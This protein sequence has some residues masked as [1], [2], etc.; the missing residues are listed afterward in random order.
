[1]MY[2]VMLGPDVNKRG[3]VRDVMLIFT[4]PTIIRFKSE[5]QIPVLSSI[6]ERL[7]AFRECSIFTDGSVVQESDPVINTFIPSPA[8]ARMIGVKPLVA[9]AMVARPCGPATHG[10]SIAF[11]AV[12]GQAAGCGNSY[13]IEMVMLA[14]ACLVRDQMRMEG[15]PLFAIWSDCKSAVDKASQVDLARVRKSGHKDHGLLIRRMFYSRFKDS[16]LLQHVK[17]HPE[18][19]LP[20]GQRWQELSGKEAGIYLA[21]RIADARM[22]EDAQY[23]WEN[24]GSI[25][26]PM[27]TMDVAEILRLF[28]SIDLWSIVDESGNPILDSPL[29]RVQAR[30]FD[31]YLRKRDGAREEK[32][33]TTYVPTAPAVVFPY[34]RLYHRRA[35]VT[36]VVFNWYLRAEQIGGACYSRDG[37]SVMEEHVGREDA[38][39]DD[40]MLPSVHPPVGMACLLCGCDM[41]RDTERHLYTFCNHVDVKMIRSEAEE[42]V[43]G[44]VLGTLEGPI[45]S[46]ASRLQAVLLDTENQHRTWKGIITPAQIQMIRA[47]MDDAVLADRNICQMIRKALTSC[48]QVVGAAVMAMRKAAWGAG[49]AVVVKQNWKPSKDKGQGTER[50]KSGSILTLLGVMSPKEAVCWELSRRVR[51]ASK[52]GGGRCHGGEVV[53][54]EVGSRQWDVH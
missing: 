45:R 42:K 36:K 26:T 34:E 39:P 38:G 1:M 44:L 33:W 11:R 29:T 46:A 21:D 32:I 47:G 28:A 12:N 27:V 7:E 17:G 25:R 19:G 40:G 10:L 14:F 6:H 23:I 43:R 3:I 5:M 52:Q 22:S 41:L 48:L 24:D 31:G 49:G 20:K 2:R 53:E 13:D 54:E 18:R 50:G 51:R 35:K 37:G 9:G 4:Q 15:L 8:I 30:R 16:T